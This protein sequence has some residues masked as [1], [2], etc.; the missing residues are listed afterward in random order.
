MRKKHSRIVRT[1]FARTLWKEQDLLREA[2]ADYPPRRIG[3]LDDI[4][5]ALAFRASRAGARLTGQTIVVDGGV[6]LLGL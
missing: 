3:E 5:G 2:E 4:A 1:G 6:S